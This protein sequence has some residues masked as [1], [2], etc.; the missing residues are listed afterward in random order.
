MFGFYVMNNVGIGFR[1]FA[2][3]IFLGLGSAVILVVNGLFI[4]A[5]ARH[6]TR[7]SLGKTFW[8]FVVGRGALELTAITI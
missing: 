8:P 1:S 7:L 6:L 3:G 4:G 5:A 2:S